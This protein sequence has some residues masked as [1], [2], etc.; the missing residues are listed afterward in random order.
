M[1]KTKYMFVLFIAIAVLTTQVGSVLAAPA[2]QDVVIDG[3]VTALECVTEDGATILVTFDDADGVSQTVEVDLETAKTLGLVT[4][5]EGD[6]PDCSEEAFQAILDALSEDKPQH[7]VGAAL[8]IFFKDV[9]DYD[10][11]MGAHEDG[12]GFGVIAQALWLTMKLEGDSDTFL[13][14]LLAKET[15]DFSAFFEEGATAP[16]NWGQF[17]KE[18]LNGDKKSN[19]GAVMSDKDKDEDKTNNGKGQDKE[20]TNNGKG[21]D[22]DKNKDD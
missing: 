1:K 14:I 20:K 6:V 5:G 8:S 21:H 22:K 9:S 10:T 3:T 7:P 12:A 11:I 16:T 13:D 4:I 19:L 15:K 17:K 18:I 2:F